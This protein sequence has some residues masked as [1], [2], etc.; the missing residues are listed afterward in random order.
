M[1]WSMNFDDVQCKESLGRTVGRTDERQL[2]NFEIVGAND[3]TRNL[4]YS[5][6]NNTKK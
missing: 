4:L 1:L 3:F 5:E 2:L 6:G